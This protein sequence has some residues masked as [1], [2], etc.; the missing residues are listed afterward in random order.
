MRFDLT[1]LRLFLAITESGS[2]TGGAARAH[3][4][5]A[6]ASARIRGLEEEIGTPLLVRSRSGAVPTPAGEALAHHARL[7]L[8]QAEHMRGDLAR[9]GKG[10]KGHLRIWSNTAALS[11][12]LPHDL[13]AFLGDH[14]DIDADLE[15]H[16]SAVIVRALREGLIHVGVLS[17]AVGLESLDS[18]AYDM[19]RLMALL[20]RGHRLAGHDR[21][22]FRDLAA[23]PFVGLATGIAMQ[24]MITGEA[25]RQG[26]AL[27]LRVRATSFA[28]L[29]EFV[30]A[31]VGVAI[32]PD[33]EVRRLAPSLPV[34]A[35][36]IA[37]GWTR[38]TL[39]IAVRDRGALPDFARRAYDVLAGAEAPA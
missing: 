1:D 37:D 29:A 34:E 14:P 39:A 22:A 35:C 28:G 21:L 19:D 18:R 17:S 11:G 26:L 7:L 33:T 13:A 8:Q 31:G 9:Y 10:L 27:K 5:L 6:S 23:E 20:P 15:E 38:R 30:A 2:I 25:A 32:L 36:A 4:A 24:D 16:P 12:R 3:L